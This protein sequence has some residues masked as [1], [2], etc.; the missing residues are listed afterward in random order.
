MPRSVLRLGQKQARETGTANP[1]V[2][3]ATLS[4]AALGS[5][6]MSRALGEKAQG[7]AR[8]ATIAARGMTPPVRRNGDAP[9]SERSALR[10]E[11]STPVAQAFGPSDG[12]RRNLPPAPPARGTGRNGRRERALEHGGC[13]Q[14]AAS[15]PPGQCL[16]SPPSSIAVSGARPICGRACG[17][18]LL[19][20]AKSLPMPAISRRRFRSRLAHDFEPEQRQSENAART[21]LQI[22]AAGKGDWAARTSRNSGDASRARLTTGGT[23]R[24]LPLRTSSCGVLSIGAERDPRIGVQKEPLGW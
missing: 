17:P 3:G 7:R 8:R 2:S 22:A 9:K 19:F 6:P 5:Q 1:G 23:M 14:S 13:F 18:R 12:G 15:R 24:S 21:S 16:S 20:E 4:R 10:P 11:V